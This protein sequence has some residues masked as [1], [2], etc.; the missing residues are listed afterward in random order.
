MFNQYL[1]SS[2]HL[3]SKTPEAL[4]FHPQRSVQMRHSTSKI[5]PIALSQVSPVPKHSNTRQ[6]PGIEAFRATNTP[7]NTKESISKD[8]PYHPSKVQLD[9]IS[10]IILR[11]K[12]ESKTR[13]DERFQR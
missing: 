11:F 6:F 1:G 7:T 5:H 8:N 10:L 3:H 4:I 13:G 9:E 2:S 12:A